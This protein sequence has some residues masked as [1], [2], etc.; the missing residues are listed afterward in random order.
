MKKYMV[1]PAL[2]AFCLHTADAQ[3]FD[4]NGLVIES[5][6]ANSLVLGQ[7]NNA[8]TSIPPGAAGTLLAGNGSGS[9][10]SFQTPASL[11]LIPG[12]QSVDTM[13]LLRALPTVSDEN[14]LVGGYYTRGDVRARV[15][16]CNASDTTTG[17]F[18]TGSITTTVLTVTAITNGAFA[19][20]QQ[21]NGPNILPGTYIASLGSGTGGTGTYNL[22]QSQTAASAAVCGD[23]GGSVI[24]SNVGA[25][26]YL[27]DLNRVTIKDF[28]A[29]GNG[30]FSDDLPVIQYA[31]WLTGKGGGIMYVPM[32]NYL[33][34]Q[35]VTLSASISIQGDGKLISVFAPS[36][37]VT[38]AAFKFQPGGLT[39]TNI[40]V[41][42]IGV[43]GNATTV[44]SFAFS[45]LTFVSLQR[46][47]MSG[48]TNTAST[49][50]S[51]NDVEDSSIIGCAFMGICGNG[52]SLVTNSNNNLFL[53]NTFNTTVANT[54]GIVMDQTTQ[55]TTIIGNNFEGTSAGNV[56]INC[57]GSNTTSILSNYMEYWNGACIQ[58][59]SA[60]YP[61]YNL[62]IRDNFLLA[63]SSA[64]SFCA[65]N[66]AAGNVGVTIENNFLNG[67][68]SGGFAA[69]G[70]YVDNT[71]GLFVR[72]NKTNGTGT[73]MIHY[74]GATLTQQDWTPVFPNVQ[75]PASTS[76]LTV[77]PNQG[78]VVYITL[79]QNLGVNAP[80]TSI[81]GELLTYH[82]LQ[83]GTGGY[84]VGWDT[85]HYV[86]I[87]F[88]NTGNTANT[89][90]SISFRCVAAGVW[91]QEG[92]Q[93]T[94]S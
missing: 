38:G 62:S 3:T 82:F 89:R 57:S 50:V 20:G 11:G 87:A 52:C 75:T 4:V 2:L 22:N 37:S 81:V 25:R 34:N 51:L 35:T 56:A 78:S 74:G 13:A 1:L 80:S 24:V 44:N 23:N 6:P 30:T 69:V 65:L 14:I 26:W 7:G 9:A 79:N 86:N 43:S 28:G 42:D 46:V 29:K 17:A 91:L 55:N 68:G 31:S 70:F 15:Y 64:A 72:G 21:I 36:T 48:F 83:N 93:K 10:P 27:A 84:T 39:T 61:T 54:N 12:L 32:G 18:G 66:S 47:Y 16:Y 53:G 45:N 94:W 63:T 41:A 33:L 73:G 5:V 90:S 8:V 19:V 92:A 59:N 76:S 60:T 77:D 85:S 58:A 49:L 67:L 40:L 71:T 88:S